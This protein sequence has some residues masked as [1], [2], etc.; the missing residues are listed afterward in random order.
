MKVSGRPGP[1]GHLQNS[2]KPCV[3]L[4]D[5]AIYEAIDGEK[6]DQYPLTLLI[7]LDRTKIY[8]RQKR[9]H[10]AHGLFHF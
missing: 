10:M 8:Q 9:W 1:P 6:T 7:N 5:E 3:V 2:P 4:C